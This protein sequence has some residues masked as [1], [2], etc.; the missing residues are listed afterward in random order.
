[1][2]A[3]SGLTDVDAITLST[4]RL[5]NSGQLGAETGWRVIL[6][7]ALAN[8]VFKA[9]IAIGAGGRHLARTVIPYFAAAGIGGALLLA[10]WPSSN[11]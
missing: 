1:V 10:F 9:G 7:G 6:V 3:I 8:L 5:I 11:L 2:A 4:S